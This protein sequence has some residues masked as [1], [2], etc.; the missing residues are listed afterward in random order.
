LLP[1]G[2]GALAVQP[3]QEVFS[4]QLRGSHPDQQLPAGVAAAALLD[5]A[6]HRVERPITSNRST[7]SL[8][9]SIPDT[10]VNV[11]SGVPI[12]TRCRP[13]RRPRMLAT[14]W[15]GL[16]LVAWRHR[17][18]EERGTAVPEV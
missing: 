5:R 3:D 4:G 17:F 15:F 2:V 14:R 9:A 8:T 16:P 6:D 12:R 10:G 11:G 18:E 13:R 1:G 7:S